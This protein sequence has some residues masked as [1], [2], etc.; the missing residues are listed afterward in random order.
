[1]NKKYSN[2]G[3]VDLNTD[4]VNFGK[5]GLSAGISK[6]VSEDAVSFVDSIWGSKTAAGKVQDK[7]MEQM[8]LDR[9][10]AERETQHLEDSERRNAMLQNELGN[11]VTRGL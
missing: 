2:G 8:K 1:M 7:R 10:R 6:D 4:G 3:V 11:G 5:D 9:F